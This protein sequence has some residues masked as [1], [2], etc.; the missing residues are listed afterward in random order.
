MSNINTKRVDSL[1]QDA[2][3]L[4]KALS[5]LVKVYQFRDRKNICYYDVS[6]TQCYALDALMILGSM[7][8]N[9]L[10]QHLYLDKSTAS[11]VVDSLENKGYLNREIDANDARSKILSVTPEGVELYKKIEHDLIKEMQNLIEDLDPEIRGATIHL[12]SRLARTASERFTKK[13]KK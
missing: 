7:S 6:V 11:R 5:E 10:A 1:E 4:Q 8:Q 13:T 9:N 12:I 2:F 3:A